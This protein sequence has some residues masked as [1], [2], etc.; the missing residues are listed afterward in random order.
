MKLWILLSSLALSLSAQGVTAPHAHIARITADGLKADVSYLASDELEGRA[1]P[2]PGLDK[3]ADFLAQRHE[4][5]GLKPL[6]KGSR[7]EGPLRA[8]TKNSAARLTTPTGDVVLSADRFLTTATQPLA[9]KDLVLRRI[10]ELDAAANTEPL[11]NMALLC[12]APLSRDQLAKYARKGLAALLV[13]QAPSELPRMRIPLLRLLE[14][15]AQRCTPSTRL[16]IT[17]PASTQRFASNVGGWFEGSDP[18]LKAHALVVSAHYDHIGIGPAVDGDKIRNGAD[19]DASGTAAVLAIA[20]ALKDRA[21]QRSVLFVHFYGEES[22]FLGS[23]RFVEQSPWPLKAIDAMFNLE[24]VGRPDDIGKDCAWITGWSVSDFGPLV[25]AA[26][27]PTGV[28]FYEHPRLSKMLFGSSDNLPFAEKGIVAHSI[29]AG[30]LHKQYH[31]PGD[32]AHTLDYENMARVVRATATAIE[33]MAN[34]PT[35]PAFKPG[36]T[37]AEAA[38]KR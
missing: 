3:A 30:S 14:E 8:D 15:E 2:S 4:A 27:A 6:F 36:S 38:D 37:W 33:S 32:E 28:R 13:T 5:L 1:T 7:L 10:E 34:A 17:I 35:A 21:L 26:A 18:T 29:S 25:A 31:Q 20:A 19:D 16:S 12:T 24:M 22:G 9:L 11:T 23:R